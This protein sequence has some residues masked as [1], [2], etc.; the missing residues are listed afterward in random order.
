M[1]PR[2][3][4]VLLV[5]LFLS[6]CGNDVPSTPGGMADAPPPAPSRPPPGAEPPDGTA[7][8]RMPPQAGASAP[9]ITVSQGS[10][11]YLV[12]ASGA[13]LYFLQGNRDGTRCD[14]V[15]EGAWPP[16]TSAQA[17]A[18]AGPGVEAARL[19]VRA[20]PDGGSQVTYAQQPL[21]RYAGD[22]GAGRTSGH[23]VQDKWGRWSLLAPS[24]E[25]L[26]AAPAALNPAERDAA[27]ER[28]A[29]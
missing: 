19:G 11:S 23:R 21:Y 9:A 10:P 4:A 5:P 26:A 3:A 15:C 29:R 1:N 7:T 13:S 24:G 20:R 28:P 27:R 12:D 16:V 6:A 25:A 17:R 2:A 22:A 8:E 18:S 14:A